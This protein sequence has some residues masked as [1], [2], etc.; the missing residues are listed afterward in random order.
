IHHVQESHWKILLCPLGC[1]DLHIEDIAALEAHLATF[2]KE[3]AET[4][5]PESLIQLSKQERPLNASK[6]CELCNKE[7]D[8][9]KAYARHVGR[10]Q[11]DVALFVL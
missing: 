11:E 9:F 6:K 7:L 1:K 8:S 4:L 3:H 5:S 2:H 10:H